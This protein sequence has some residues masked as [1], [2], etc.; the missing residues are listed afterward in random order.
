MKP[1]PPPKPTRLRVLEGNPSK[2]PLH[3]NEPMPRQGAPDKPDDLSPVASEE[4]DRIVPELDRLGILSPLDR[5]MLVV[6]CEAVEIYTL[7]LAKVRESGVL[8]KGARGSE[9]VKNPALQ[10]VRDFASM[11][12][13]FGSDLGLTPRPVPECRYPTT[14]APALR[15]CWRSQTHQH[16]LAIRSPSRSQ[17]GVDRWNGDTESPIFA[18]ISGGHRTFWASLSDGVIQLRVLSRPGVH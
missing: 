16:H 7:A 18:A 13:V 9:R 3:T 15:I 6:Y 4:W 1:G 8:I 17:H 5:T 12:R 10:I 2:R 14:M 11:I